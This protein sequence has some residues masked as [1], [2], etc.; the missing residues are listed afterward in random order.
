M[1]EVQGSRPTVPYSVSPGFLFNAV[2]LEDVLVSLALW[3]ESKTEIWTVTA[4][5]AVS[6]VPLFRWQILWPKIQCTFPRP[7]LTFFSLAAGRI[8]SNRTVICLNNV[9]ICMNVTQHQA[10]VHCKPIYKQN[11]VHISSYNNYWDQLPVTR[12]CRCTTLFYLYYLLYKHVEAPWWYR[13]TN[14][15]RGFIN[16]MFSNT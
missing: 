8:F 10:G 11:C 4:Y 7:R 16:N 15:L 12:K 6:N 9:G 3:H 13:S 2:A 5:V 1:A 14:T